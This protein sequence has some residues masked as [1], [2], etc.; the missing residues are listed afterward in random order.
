MQK[1]KSWSFLEEGSVS[2]FLLPSNLQTIL[3]SQGKRQHGTVDLGAVVDFPGILNMGDG[4]L[5]RFGLVGTASDCCFVKWVSDFYLQLG[6]N[7][8]FQFFRE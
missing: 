2:N 4:M 8:N 6:D 1:V 7:T 3:E 5:Q